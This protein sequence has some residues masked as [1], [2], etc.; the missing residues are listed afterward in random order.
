MQATPV[1][2]KQRF[3][4]GVNQ[5]GLRPLNPYELK[6]PSML[7]NYG[8]DGT[9]ERIS[10]R[11]NEAGKN[12]SGISFDSASAMPEFRFFS[13]FEM[14]SPYKLQFCQGETAALRI[15]MAK[16]GS[17]CVR[18]NSLLASCLGRV[19]PLREEAR[20]MRGR[21]YD[22]FTANVSDNFTKPRSHRAHDWN[23]VV[24]AEQRVWKARQGG[25]RGKHGKS[26]SASQH[27]WS[28]PGFVKRSRLPINA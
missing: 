17:D 20:E 16:G 14:N 1:N 13:G 28:P 23:H 18:E 27:H 25:A 8:R 11:R 24:A 5:Y 7:Y 19:A 6:N 9:F 21:F 12:K 2:L 3:S 22:W 26:V 15:C 4:S 10:V